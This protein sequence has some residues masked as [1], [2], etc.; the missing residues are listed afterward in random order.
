MSTVTTPNRRL[1]LLT[2]QVAQP[3]IIDEGT[4]KGMPRVARRAGDSRLRYTI[5]L[6]IILLLG[7]GRAISHQYARN[8]A[9]A[10]YI[11][12]YADDYLQLH[13]EELNELY[14]EVDIH[15]RKFDAGDEDGD[16]FFANA[17]NSG[18]WKEVWNTEVKEFEQ[19]IRTNLTSV[20]IAIKHAGPA[21]QVTSKDKPYSSGSIIATSSTAGLRSNGGSTDY[22]AA[23]AAVV[24]LV[25]TA[26][27]QYA[28]RNIRCNAIA[29]GMTHSGMTEPV[30]YSPARERGTLHKV[31]QLCLLRRGAVADEIAR[32][33]LFLGSD[34]AS[35]VNG[36][37]WAVDGGLSS[38]LPYKL[39]SMA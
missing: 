29:P 32:V 30:F 17:A 6:Q 22:S 18:T 19:T 11:C 16:V 25:Q 37:V 31:G 4:Y 38:G 3:P 7:M 34:E 10:V 33:A 20:F 1:K 21:M 28:G 9:R 14:P 36:Q 15:A 26:C 27:Y 2:G 12:D 5:S 39:G 24:S 23:K 8:G 35:H 13:V